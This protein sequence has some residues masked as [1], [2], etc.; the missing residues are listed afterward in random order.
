LVAAIL[1]I[2]ES[3]ES[4]DLAGSARTWAPAV[5]AEPFVDTAAAVEVEWQET[6]PLI[7]PQWGGLIERV[8]VV[9][10]G[11]LSTG[12]PVARIGGVDR[13]LIDSALP[14]GRMLTEGA[15]GA[16][17]EQLNVVLRELGYAADEGSRFSAATR[18]GVRALSEVLSGIAVDEFDPGWFV[19]ATSPDMVVDSVALQPGAPAPSAGSEIVTLRPALVAG[20]VSGTQPAGTSVVVGGQPVGVVSTDG[21]IDA[22]GLAALSGLLDPESTNGEILLRRQLEDGARQVPAASVVTGANGALCIVGRASGSEATRVVA[23]DV[24]DSFLGTSTLTQLPAG[25]EEV[26]VNP[27]REDRR[28]CT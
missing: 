13:L 27:S 19:F 6:P 20:R 24:V 3:R 1:L 22:A 10:G 4:A 14:F 12:A 28:K 2:A 5:T 16:D 18:S 8:L 7:A 11:A 15:E 9:P 26:L 23:V 21:D 25:I 17:V